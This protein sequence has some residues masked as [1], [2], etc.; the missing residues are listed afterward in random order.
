MSTSPLAKLLL[1]A[2]QAEVKAAASYNEAA[3]LILRN[4][5]GRAPTPEDGDEVMAVFRLKDIAQ[6]ALD[7]ARQCA[8]TAEHLQ[9]STSVEGTLPGVGDLS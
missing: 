9:A 2:A 4:L 8:A 7:R 1:E 6:G 3:E 5:G